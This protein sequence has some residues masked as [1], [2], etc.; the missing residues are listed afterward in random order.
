MKTI[1]KEK[2]KELIQY[3]LDSE[4]IRDI[5]EKYIIKSIP[6]ETWVNSQVEYLLAE[7]KIKVE[8]GKQND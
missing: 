4:E 5:Y 3:C 8:G 2:E 1:T 6:F 7:N